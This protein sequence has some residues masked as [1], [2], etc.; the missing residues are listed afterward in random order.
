MES[1]A[2]FG[3]ASE[4]KN[5]RNFPLRQQFGSAA[6][7]LPASMVLDRKWINIFCG[8]PPG[9]ATPETNPRETE[10]K[11]REYLPLPAAAAKIA[12]P[13]DDQPCLGSDEANKRAATRSNASKSQMGRRPTTPRLPF[14]GIPT[15]LRGGRAHEFPYGVRGQPIP[16]EGAYIL[17]LSSRECGFRRMSTDIGRRPDRDEVRDRSF[18]IHVADVGNLRRCPWLTER[19]RHPAPSSVFARTSGDDNSRNFPP[20]PW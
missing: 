10:A 18:A 6:E 16:A 8:R 17:G 19:S 13:W 1:V 7:F 4:G 20:L 3:K 2:G 12:R 9:R 11:F 15:R 14:A 5:T